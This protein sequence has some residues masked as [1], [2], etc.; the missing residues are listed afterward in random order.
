MKEELKIKKTKNYFP[1]CLL[2]DK[3]NEKE[4]ISQLLI[5]HYENEIPT[6]LQKTRKIK[7]RKTKEEDKVLSWHF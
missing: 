4:F 1:Y 2:M 5:R 6:I 3:D 7:R